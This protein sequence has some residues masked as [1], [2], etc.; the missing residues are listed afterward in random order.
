[1]RVSMVRVAAAVLVAAGMAGCAVE[2]PVA[3][4]GSA[5]PSPATPTP[6]ITKA[7][8]DSSQVLTGAGFPE[9]RG[10][11]RDATLWG[12]LFVGAPPIRRGEQTKIV[13]RM[14]GE[15]PVR[16]EA[17]LPDGT[18]AKL[19]W[20]PEEHEGST[21]RRPGDEWGTGFVFPRAGCWKIQLT[22]TRGSGH[23]W[24]A[25]R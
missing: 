10:T 1:M 2:A 18:A 6:M 11:A 25:V 5:A 21:W 22:R 3:A 9:V 13:W 14:T 23:V 15:G 12:L 8:C 4:R 17:T 20:G 7:G 16:V 24:L 19:L